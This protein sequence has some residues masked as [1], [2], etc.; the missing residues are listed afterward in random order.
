MCR[1][2]PALPPRP[3]RAPPRRPPHPRHLP[4]PR[5]LGRSPHVRR[6]PC[7]RARPAAPRP[8]SLPQ[9]AARAAAAPAR[10][11]NPR[12]LGPAGLGRR[13]WGDS[14]RQR[15][16]RRVLLSSCPRARPSECRTPPAAASPPRTGAP[17]PEPLASSPRSLP[18]AA[19]VGAGRGAKSGADERREAI[20]RARRLLANA[21]EGTR[22]LVESRDAGVSLDAFSPADWAFVLSRCAPRVADAHAAG[23][24][25]FDAETKALRL[26]LDAF[27]GKVPARLLIWPGLEGATPRLTALRTHPVLRCLPPSAH[28]RRRTPQPRALHRTHLAAQAC[29]SSRPARPH[30]RSLYSS[31]T[32]TKHALRCCSGRMRWRWCE[33]AGEETYTRELDDPRKG[34][35]FGM[36]AGGD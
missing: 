27:T 23:T 32:C 6:R 9:R 2:A 18:H 10:A 30:C 33:R 1:E 20:T 31:P 28:R 26:R 15:G 24:P 17:K 16:P 8:R 35:G 21:R 3:P 13:A 34:H 12:P 11:Y 36:S 29:P 25:P 5:A 19:G 22:R 4:L 7:R 14:R